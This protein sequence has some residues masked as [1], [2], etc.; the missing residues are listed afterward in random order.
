MVVRAGPVAQADR[1]DRAVLVVKAEYSEILVPTTVAI[2]V[3]VVT[4][5][6]AGKADR[7]VRDVTAVGAY[8][9]G[10]V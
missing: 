5:A 1:A 7:A 2:T 8:L 10:E 9:A 6:M 3:K 4:G